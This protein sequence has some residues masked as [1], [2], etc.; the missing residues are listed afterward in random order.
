MVRAPNT[1][2]S[3]ILLEIFALSIV[4]GLARLFLLERTLIE[5]WRQFFGGIFFGSLLGY[6]AYQFPAKS[7]YYA[8][9]GKV[10]RWWV[11][12]FAVFG[13]EILS[14]FKTIIIDFAPIFKNFILKQCIRIKKG[15]DAY[16]SDSN[17]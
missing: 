6:L 9:T 12:L 3:H 7:E 1:E 15:F 2:I 17:D 13:K 11:A 8:Y 10:W 4:S 14:L 5:G 16:K